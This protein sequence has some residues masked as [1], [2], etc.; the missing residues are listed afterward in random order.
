MEQISTLHYT[1]FERIPSSASYELMRF[2]LIKAISTSKYSRWRRYSRA[3]ATISWLGPSSEDSKLA[4]E[5]LAKLDKWTSCFFWSIQLAKEGYPPPTKVKNSA[6]QIT[7][8]SSTWRLPICAPA[9]IGPGY[10]YSRRWQVHKKDISC[11]VIA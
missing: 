7:G 1:A 8:D 10:G 2:A 3:R 9:H 5:T 4:L 11:A 6:L